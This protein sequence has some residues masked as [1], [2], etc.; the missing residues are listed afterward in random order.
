MSDLSVRRLI[1][2]VGLVIV[3]L[4]WAMFPL[5]VISWNRTPISGHRKVHRI[6]QS[7]KRGLYPYLPVYWVHSDCT[8]LGSSRVCNYEYRYTA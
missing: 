1:G 5:Y 3:A 6:D 8:L 7:T 4:N 2:V